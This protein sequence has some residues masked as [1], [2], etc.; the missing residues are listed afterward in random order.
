M[1]I[2]RIE[3]L[4]SQQDVLHVHFVHAVQDQQD[5]LCL[6]DLLWIVL[7]FVHFT[8]EITVDDLLQRFGGQ[9]LGELSEYIGLV[10]F[11]T[12]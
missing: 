8:E 11:D 3:A 7:Q 9:L 1:Y 5:E 2:Q 6:G 12:N 10:L 4:G